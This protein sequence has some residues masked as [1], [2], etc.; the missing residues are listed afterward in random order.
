MPYAK[1]T[2]SSRRRARTPLGDT[3]DEHRYGVTMSPSNDASAPGAKSD[4][5][6]RPH[7]RSRVD[8]GFHHEAKKAR[9]EANAVHP[10]DEEVRLSQELTTQC[11]AVM[12]RVHALLDR[13]QQQEERIN[14]A[15]HESLEVSP[16]RQSST[17]PR[18]AA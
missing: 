2:V 11:D 15:L 9:K 6:Q 5:L 18:K 12:Q 8:S 16:L 7:M 1:S 13:S 17:S 14:R 4:P 3:E 10:H